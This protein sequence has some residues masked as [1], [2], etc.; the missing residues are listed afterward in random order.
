METIQPE[1]PIIQFRDGRWIIPNPRKMDLIQLAHYAKRM[2]NEGDIA[3]VEVDETRTRTFDFGA[4][5]E[6]PPAEVNRLLMN[7]ARVMQKA[8][9]VTALPPNL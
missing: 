3:I 9:L 1:Q 7:Y 2:I 4:L 5:Q 8:Q 6:E